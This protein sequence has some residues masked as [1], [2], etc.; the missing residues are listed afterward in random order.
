MDCHNENSRRIIREIME[1]HK[2]NVYSIEKRGRK[3]LICQTPWMDGDVLKC[4]AD[5]YA[6]L[7]LL[8]F[9]SDFN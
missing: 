6:E 8:I 3:K 4:I 1:T 9:V 5:D 7:F 2:K